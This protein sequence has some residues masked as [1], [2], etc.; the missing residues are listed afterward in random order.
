MNFIVFYEPNEASRVKYLMTHDAP[1]SCNMVE[2]FVRCGDNSS[3]CLFRILML[4]PIQLLIIH[5]YILLVSLLNFEWIVFLYVT[6][7]R[8]V[9][10]SC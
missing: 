3:V 2:E 8:T 4:I 6:Y 1:L 7:T 5:F 9:T 10:S